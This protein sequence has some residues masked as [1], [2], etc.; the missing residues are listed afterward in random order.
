M[1]SAKQH[2]RRQ[3]TKMRRFFQRAPGDIAEEI[4]EVL[5]E[6]AQAVQFDAI[7]LAKSH[8]VQQ[9]LAHPSAIAVGSNGLKVEFGMR[10]KG[11]KRIA[12]FAHFLEFGTRPHYNL[13][14][15]NTR[16]KKRRG[17]IIPGGSGWH[18]GMPAQP[19]LV[20]AIEMNREENRRRRDKAVR[21][22]MN[23]ALKKAADG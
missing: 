3:A 11:Q 19:F 22:A 6:S 10:T 1:V 14:G 2:N 16:K 20:P 17:V 7:R 18:P 5:L 9:A 12:F 8:R 4:K 15:H 23:M 13:K 21:H